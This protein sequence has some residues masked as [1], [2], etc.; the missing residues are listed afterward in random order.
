MESR[1]H[2]GFYG[3]DWFIDFFFKNHQ[4]PRSKLS[5]LLMY[6]MKRESS[7]LDFQDPAPL[8]GAHCTTVLT[9]QTAYK[10]TGYKIRARGAGINALPQLSAAFAKKSSQILARSRGN[11]LAAA[12]ILIPPNGARSLN[13]CRRVFYIIRLFSLCRLIARPT[14]IVQII[15][16][17]TK[18]SFFTPL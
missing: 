18:C 15:V 3:N 17:R 2:W 14:S 10:V 11:R 8:G 5:K 6:R 4:E 7:L 1:N 13:L 16:R 12:E 9:V